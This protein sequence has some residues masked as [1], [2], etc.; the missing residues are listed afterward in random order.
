MGHD[1]AFFSLF[2]IFALEY[3]ALEPVLDLNLRPSCSL[4]GTV[5]EARQV[6]VQQLRKPV[7]VCL[8]LVKHLVIYVKFEHLNILIQSELFVTDARIDLVHPL[9]SALAGCA[10]LAT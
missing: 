1:V 3:Q 4:P 6:L 5:F 7:P 9:L 10:T 2:Y 8:W